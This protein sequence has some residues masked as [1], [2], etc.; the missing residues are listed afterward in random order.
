MASTHLSLSLLTE[1]LDSAF[2]AGSNVFE[3]YLDFIGL[4]GDQ[5]SLS[6]R[7]YPTNLLQMSPK[8]QAFRAVV[9][10]LP[11]PA[12]KGVLSDCSSWGGVDSIM[13]GNVGLDDFV[14]HF[15]EYRRAVGLEPRTL[16]VTLQKDL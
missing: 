5:N 12:I 13:Y 10:L 4:T 1:A 6:V 16:R 15:D 14:F 8:E 9:K 7:L 3:A 2:R 11:P